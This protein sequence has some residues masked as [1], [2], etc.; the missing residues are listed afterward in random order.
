MIAVCQE[1]KKFLLLNE[2]IFSYHERYAMVNPFGDFAAEI[3]KR[4][5]QSTER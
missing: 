3:S 1:S 5:K 4:R 2:R